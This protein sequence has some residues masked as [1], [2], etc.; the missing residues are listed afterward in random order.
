MLIVM[1]LI[2]AFAC[3][4]VYATYGQEEFLITLP[5][6]VIALVSA[7]VLGV[8][9]KKILNKK[10]LSAQEKKLKT[11]TYNNELKKLKAEYD[12]EQKEISSEISSLKSNISDLKKK[13]V[14][15]E[16]AY[17][18]LSFELDNF[19]QIPDFYKKKEY[20]EKIAS[21]LN[22]GLADTLQS[23]LVLF[24]QYRRAELLADLQRSE[25]EKKEA[26][27][28]QN[29]YNRYMAKR[30][31][32]DWKTEQEYKEIRSEIGFNVQKAYDLVEEAD[33]ARR[34]ER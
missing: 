16:S 14:D 5:P 26:D 18:R 7:V 23:A 6:Y 24:E 15:A 28:K 4:F 32:N 34:A 3:G 30:G 1:I 22:N 2:S 19:E 13:K 12:K 20:L 10:T 8:I 33:S 9:Y 27:E 29:M 11:D 21:Y 17:N 31:Y 25:Q